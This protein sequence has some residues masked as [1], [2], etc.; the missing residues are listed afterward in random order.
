MQSIVATKQKQTSGTGISNGNAISALPYDHADFCERFLSFLTNPSGNVHRQGA[1][2]LVTL[3]RTACA[4]LKEMDCCRL[5]FSWRTQWRCHSIEFAT[6]PPR[7]TAL[8]LLMCSF[9]QSL[10]V[11]I[12]APFHHEQFQLRTPRCSSSINQPVEL[13]SAR[14][15]PTAGMRS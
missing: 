10:A 15:A 12:A 6:V 8:S 2:S 13:K 4:A 14:V 9:S 3:D 11:V 1:A 7:E 5:S